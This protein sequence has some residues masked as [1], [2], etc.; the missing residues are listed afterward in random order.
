MLSK[1][2][3]RGFAGLMLVL[4]PTVLQAQVSTLAEAARAAASIGVATSVSGIVTLPGGSLA[5]GLLVRL[6]D[7]VTGEVVGT[8]ITSPMGEFSFGEL[9]TGDFI[10]EIIDQNGAI[11]TVSSVLA[12][13]PGEAVAALVRIPPPARRL[14]NVLASALGGAGTAASV[15]GTAGTQ[16]VAVVMPPGP[17]ISPE[18]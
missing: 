5:G 8:T 9:D 2:L 6:R 13:S 4:A 12:I 11:L 16:G 7:A 15:L 14:N 10:I 18:Q 1:A 17:P 3:I